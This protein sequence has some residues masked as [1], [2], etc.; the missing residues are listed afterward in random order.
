MQH[1]TKTPL[2]NAYF[3]KAV[4]VM[5]AKTSSCNKRLTDHWLLCYTALLLSLSILYNRMSCSL[6]SVTSRTL[7][8]PI[9]VY[10]AGVKQGR[11]MLACKCSKGMC[12]ALQ[13]LIRRYTWAMCQ[14]S[15]ATCVTSAACW[16]CFY[17][18]RPLE[19]VIWNVMFNCT[20]WAPS[21]VLV[22]T[23]TINTAF[24]TTIALYCCVTGQ[25]CQG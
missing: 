24:T 16:R 23:G 17:Y 7:A 25:M 19:V 9:D 22:L 12:T 13:I 21:L 4:I 18:A 20:L 3:C 6:S 10:W 2:W 1:T 8:Q 15:V 11:P 5:I 14:V